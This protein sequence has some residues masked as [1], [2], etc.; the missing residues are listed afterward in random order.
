MIIEGPAGA[1]PTKP[2]AEDN[3]QGLRWRNEKKIFIFP[4]FRA[5][6]RGGDEPAM[7]F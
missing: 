5:K 6:N 3:S 7:F 2:P 4:R 1:E